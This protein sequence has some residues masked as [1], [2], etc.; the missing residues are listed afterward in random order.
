V[1]DH[2]ARSGG[3]S[4]SEVGQS[5]PDR[6]GPAHVVLRCRGVESVELLGGQ[7]DRHDPH[8]FSPATRAPAAPTLENVDAVSR[9]GLIGPLLNLLFARHAYIV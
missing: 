5:G 1:D 8:R 6:L 7:P 2:L 9:F 3:P 4:R